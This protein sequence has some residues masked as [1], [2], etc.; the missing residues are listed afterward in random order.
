MKHAAGSAHYQYGP[1]T[2]TVFDE[3]TQDGVTTSEVDTF[4]HN[5]LGKRLD[6][7]EKAVKEMSDHLMKVGK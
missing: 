7:I 3:V 5:V 2:M 4:D 1:D 6:A